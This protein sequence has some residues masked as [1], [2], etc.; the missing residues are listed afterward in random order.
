MCRRGGI[1]TA[2]TLKYAI[3]WDGR[4]LPR[5]ERSFRANEGLQRRP[6]RRRCRCSDDNDVCLLQTAASKVL[7]RPRGSAFENGTENSTTAFVRRVRVYG[8]TGAAQEGYDSKIRGGRGDR[9]ACVH[10]VGK[11]YEETVTQA[12]TGVRIEGRAHVYVRVSR[13]R[14]R[15]SVSPNP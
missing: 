14:L 10:V 1:D 4:R 12:P 8:K 9:C 5:P 11:R 6:G 2:R 7:Q 3:N 13:Y 15:C